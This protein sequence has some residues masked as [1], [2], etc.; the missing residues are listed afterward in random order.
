MFERP[1]YFDSIQ[2]YAEGEWE[3][4]DQASWK[5]SVLLLFSEV[6]SPQ[7]VI[8][9]LLQNADDAGAKKAS[10][11]I[12]RDTF[13]FEHDGEDFTAEQ[14]KS[15]CSF[16]ISSKA[17]LHTIGFRGIGFKS[18][19]SLGPNV[20]I[21]TP[22]L[23]FEFNEERF[24]VPV[25]NYD[26]VPSES[27][28]VR[29]E[30]RDTAIRERARAEIESWYAHPTP[31]LFFQNIEHLELQG[32]PVRKERLGVGPVSNASW[33]RLTG[34][35][36]RLLL[37]VTS[38]VE[39]F[40]P[41]ALTEIVKERRDADGKLNITG[42]SVD[43]VL[44]EDGEPRLYVVLPTEVKPKLSFSCNAPFLQDPSRKT[45]KDPVNSPTNRWL[46]RRIGELAASTLI[47]W[48]SNRELDTA[49]RAKAY[50][51]VSHPPAIDT[52]IGGVTTSAVLKE[53]ERRLAR[54]RMLL[55]SSGSLEDIN[56]MCRDTI[57]PVLGLG[58]TN[59]SRDLR[60][61]LCPPARS[62]DHTSVAAATPSVGAVT[63]SLRRRGH[64]RTHVT[65]TAD[66]E[67]GPKKNTC[68]VGFS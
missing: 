41:E 57:S 60:G 2:Q 59:A 13:V 21:T 49:E 22:T 16:G 40:P 29:V 62:T 36:T 14:F 30:L 19:F 26:A 45:I 48:I 39:P 46:L 54:R 50:D 23:A 55:S 67:P 38:E 24:T 52:S 20:Q 6:Q 12:E 66:S 51:L 18:V 8:S 33:I 10:I 63:H 47:E 9:E 37:H 15:L 25:W 3:V 7:H 4:L 5:N 68:P 1:S 56:H 11:A 65:R 44:K 28:V 61:Q 32:R 27:T 34:R 42:C 53:F 31:L 43:I 58:R 17:R 64:G 35:D